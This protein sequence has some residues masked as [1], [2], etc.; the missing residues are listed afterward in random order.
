LESN[1][2]NDMEEKGSKVKQNNEEKEEELDGF[3]EEPEDFYQPPPQPTRRTYQRKQD[4]KEE[5]VLDLVGSHPLWGHFL[6]NAALVL[7]DYFD[8]P[9]NRHILTNKNV[10]ELGAGGALPSIIALK[11]NA[12]RVVVTDYPDQDLLENIRHNIHAN[13]TPQEA[14]SAVILGHLW[15]SSVEGLLEA[16][17]PAKIEAAQTEA[18]TR[19]TKFD[20][21]IMSDLIFNHSQHNQLL[22]TCTSALADDGQVFVSYSHHR[23]HYA[24][25][26]LKFFSLAESNYGLEVRRLFSKMMTPMFEKDFGPEAVRATV[27]LCILTKTKK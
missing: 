5:V 18:E 26:D 16:I 23:P 8:E 14:S 27:H 11:N 13:T 12:R 24:D 20:V 7:A 9:D 19:P 4:L 1:S 15:G 10:L 2:L 6:W 3:F 25:R 22:K 21:I 17:A